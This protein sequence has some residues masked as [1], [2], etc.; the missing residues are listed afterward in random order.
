MSGASSARSSAEAW[1]IV[2][3]AG[4]GARFG[5]TR[6]KQFEPLAGRPLLWWTLQAFVRHPDL[7]GVVLV[8]AP[9]MAGAPP[10][11]VRSL[12]RSGALP[13]RVA[14]GGAERRDSVW[15]GLEAAPADAALVVVHDGVRPCVTPEMISAVVA[16]ARE[17][18]G[19]VIGRPLTD[20]LKETAGAGEILRTLPRE[21]LWR[22]ETPQ[23][24]PRPMLE[25]A[26]RASRER[27]IAATDCAALCERAGGRLVMV[28][29]SDPNPKVTSAAD[30][31][32]V[33]AWLRRRGGDDED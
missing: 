10:E 4:R 18:V 26:Y 16:R 15:A 2:V 7:A 23:A 20:T 19:A 9:E 25:R 17:G 22:A 31:A 5:G 30:L 33:E 11:W 1:A 24:F 28:E 21:R 3:A 27:G 8:L 12:A 13:L 14:A 6:P 29:A 32:W